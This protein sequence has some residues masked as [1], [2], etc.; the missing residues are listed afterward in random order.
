MDNGHRR[1]E[2]D[3]LLSSTPSPLSEPSLRLPWTQE[4]VIGISR[5]LGESRE[6]LELRLKSFREMSNASWINPLM[7]S[8]RRTDPQ[9]FPRGGSY[10]LLH[11]FLISLSP[12]FPMNAPSFTW[13]VKSSRSSEG[14]HFYLPSLSPAVFEDSPQLTHL[15]TA[16]HQD[17]LLLKILTGEELPQPIKVHSVAQLEEGTVGVS[18]HST[19]LEEN[20]RGTILFYSDWRS[21]H[22][23]WGYSLNHFHLKPRSRLQLLLFTR[24]QSPIRLYDHLIVD[25]EEESQLLLVSAEVTEGIG[26]LRREVYIHQPGGEALIRGGFFGRKEARLDYRTRQFHLAEH[27]ISDLLF[28]SVLTDQSYSLYQ[29]LI[30]V[31]PEAR[32]ANAYQLNRNLI[33]NEKAKAET[34]PRLEIM[35]DEVRCT[36]GASVGKPDEEILYYLRSRGLTQD[37]AIALFIEG[38][39]HDVTKDLSSPSLQDLWR[40]EFWRENRLARERL[41]A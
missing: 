1:L 26:V 36:H 17:G 31:L 2:G 12:S 30:R 39:I 35:V 5:A 15:I 27:T 6:E 32:L 34:I 13:A 20:A 19:I 41:S 21:D 25:M 23:A 3:Y 14:P 9:L 11:P 33:L 37:E 18:L 38:F 28:K 24:S 7:E 22:L 8:W 40:Q 29:G 10:H 16:F 4:G